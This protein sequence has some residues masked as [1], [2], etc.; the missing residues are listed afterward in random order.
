LAPAFK[1]DNLDKQ[2]RSRAMAKVRARGNASTELRAV[3]LFRTNGITGWRRHL[4]LAGRPD[5]AFP[6]A[7]L[8]VFVDGCFW[9]G[10]PR[11]YRAPQSSKVFWRAKLAENKAR[12]L[13]VNRQLRADGWKVLRVWECQLRKPAV[14]LRRLAKIS[15]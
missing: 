7:K 3:K 9:H 10:C 6:R 13:V 11:C 8:A 5:F 4:P 2:Q 1:V 15:N 12:D 14:F